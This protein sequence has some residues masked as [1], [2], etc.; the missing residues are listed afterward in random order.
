MDLREISVSKRAQWP[1]L[2]EEK[3]LTIKARTVGVAS[4]KGMGA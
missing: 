1:W 4:A 3:L 2:C